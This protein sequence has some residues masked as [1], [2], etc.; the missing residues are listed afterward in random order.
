MLNWFMQ[1]DV[2]TILATNEAAKGLF[3][4]MNKA[5][6]DAL[7]KRLLA[8]E[9][10]KS[11]HKFVN[12]SIA[13]INAVLEYIRES[14][15]RRKKLKR[16]SPEKIDLP[17][18]IFQSYYLLEFCLSEMTDIYWQTRAKRSLIEKVALYGMVSAR[19]GKTEG[20]GTRA[21]GEPLAFFAG[22]FFF[23]EYPYDERVFSICEGYW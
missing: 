4:L 14:P 11:P 15:A 22:S 10:D 21:L 13:E 3:H 20:L 16:F 5:E 19:I 6:K 23:D 7:L 8:I 9:T 2:E 12:W 18:L 17:M 1:I